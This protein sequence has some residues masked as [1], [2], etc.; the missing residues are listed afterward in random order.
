MHIPVNKVLSG[1]WYLSFKWDFITFCY[2][3]MARGPQILQCP[4]LEGTKSWNTCNIRN[5][6]SYEWCLCLYRSKEGVEECIIHPCKVPLL[7][8]PV[9]FLDVSEELLYSVGECIIILC[10]R[11]EVEACSQLLHSIWNSLLRHVAVSITQITR[12]SYFP[13]RNSGSCWLLTV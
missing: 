6:S 5:L 8:K 12:Y 10:G 2:V 3:R 1:Y 9:V 11:S 4:L 13:C 7:S